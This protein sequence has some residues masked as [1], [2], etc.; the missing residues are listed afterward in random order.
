MQK[1]K[2]VI[3]GERT[4]LE[5]AKGRKAAG[6]EKPQEPGRRT[7]SGLLPRQSSLFLSTVTCPCLHH[8]AVC[9]G[10]ACKSVPQRK[11]THRLW[12]LFLTHMDPQKDL[13]VFAA[14]MSTKPTRKVIVIP[15][16]M[17]EAL[18]WITLWISVSGA[19]NSPSPSRL[20]YLK[21]E[22]LRFKVQALQ[23]PPNPYLEPARGFLA[24]FQIYQCFPEFET[25]NSIRK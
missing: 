3:T 10:A 13:L 18:C 14:N 11:S 16:E 1:G 19:R 25:R 22:W 15:E 8:A 7:A 2:R 4:S 24:L 12:A 6:H 5:E 21:E 20:P 17:A 9:R 23:G